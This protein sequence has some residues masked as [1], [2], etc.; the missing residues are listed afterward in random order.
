MLGKNKTAPLMILFLLACA[1]AA[2]AAS[3]YINEL[4]LSRDGSFTVLTIKGSDQLRYEQQSVEAREGKPFRVVIDCLGSR[5]GLP[6]KSY[7]DLPPSIISSIRTSQFSVDPREVVRIVLD[8]NE[9]SEYRVEAEANAIKVLVSDQKT[10]PFPQ[11]TSKSVKAPTVTASVPSVE[12]KKPAGKKP[13]PGTAV[14]KKPADQ[15]R[16]PKPVANKPTGARV[17]STV[18]EA[19]NKDAAQAQ[20]PADRKKPKPQSKPGAQEKTTVASTKNSE[21][22]P[23]AKPST[24]RPSG[25]KPVPSVASRQTTRPVSRP[26]RKS[27]GPVVMKNLA[28]DSI[29]KAK[30]FASVIMS[31]QEMPEPGE[32]TD[33]AGPKSQDVHRKPTVVKAAEP[34]KPTL[35]PVTKDKEVVLASNDQPRQP[36]EGP[37]VDK[38]EEIRTS[39]YRRKSAKSA[40]MRASQVVQFP[41]RMVIKYRRN[42]TR[43]PFE[44]LIVADSKKKRNLDINK[45][46]N[47]ETLSLVGILKSLS[48][49]GLALM[50]DLDG[51]GYI[52]RTGDRV[53]NGYVAQIDKQAIYFQ[54]NEYGWGRTLVKHMEKEN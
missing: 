33:E 19:N 42:N 7:S 37:N 11:W 46:P 35:P 52:L 54:I 27:V 34:K 5:H 8:L 12:A 10:A 39:K 20:K 48:G 45:I 22:K 53:K 13:V 26:S 1:A 47:V 16:K 49:K 50:E 44:S 6:R 30:F 25:E 14:A 15:A 4:G 32:T 41:Q 40:E 51:I 24:A 2:P 9:K 36:Q 28:M 31:A 38:V 29:E 23:K 21:V 3:S 17:P 18:A 43:D